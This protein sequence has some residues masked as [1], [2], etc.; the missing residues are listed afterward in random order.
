M[1]KLFPE[2]IKLMKNPP[3]QTVFFKD[4]NILVWIKL[5]KK[6]KLI[7]P[8]L[9]NLQKYECQLAEFSATAILDTEGHVLGS[10]QSWETLIQ[11]IFIFIA[12]RTTVLYW[13]YFFSSFG[14]WVK[15]IVITKAIKSIIRTYFCHIF[16][17]MSA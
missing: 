15:Q 3:G 12:T 8:N 17:L 13:K 1:A 6:I 9:G 4:N 14:V 11:I 5:S 10:C 7:I 16:P 2:V